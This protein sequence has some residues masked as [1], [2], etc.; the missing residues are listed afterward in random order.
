MAAAG[1]LVDAESG[2]RFRPGR[3]LAD[4]ALGN[5]GRDG[6]AGFQPAGLASTQPLCQLASATG[7]KHYCVWTARS[8]RRPNNGLRRYHSSCNHCHGPDGTG[9][10][11]GPPPVESLPDI[12]NFRRIVREGRGSGNSAMKGFADDPN[13]EHYIDK[14]RANGALGRG[15]ERLDE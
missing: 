10:T 4:G 12:E 14:A 1:R 15:P 13:V 8:T 6:S 2:R 7:D 3:P 5:Y 11:I 9:S